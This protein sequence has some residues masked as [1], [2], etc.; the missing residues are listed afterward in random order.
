MKRYLL[1]CAC[2]WAAAVFAGGCSASREVKLRVEP[3]SRP[4]SYTQKFA[5]ADYSI[6]SDGEFDVILHNMVG[7]SGDQSGQLLQPTSSAP[8]QFMHVRVAWRPAIGAKANH[9]AAT[10]ASVNWYVIDDTNPREPRYLHYQGS[11]LA[12]IDM[13]GEEAVFGVKPTELRLRH[14]RGDLSD[15]IGSSLLS[16]EGK[17]RRDSGRVAALLQHLEDVLKQ[18]AAPDAAPAGK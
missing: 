15:P 16:G 9:P 11:G 1:T 14:Q 12:K 8:Q 6:R 7:P 4:V 13:D 2:A 10:N 17:A 5:A 3:M 18:A